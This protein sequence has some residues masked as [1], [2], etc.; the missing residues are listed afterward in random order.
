M[1][2]I[3][4]LEGHCRDRGASWRVGGPGWG[5]FLSRLRCWNTIQNKTTT[6]TKQGFTG[7]QKD[8][9]DVLTVLNLGDFAQVF[10]KMGMFPVFDLAYYIVSILY[11]KYEPG[12]CVPSTQSELLFF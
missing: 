9:M 6:T 5:G 12:Q 3:G 4:E 2:L 10:S 1:V 11:L 7:H 8:N